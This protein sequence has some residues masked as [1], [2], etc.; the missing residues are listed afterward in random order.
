MAD[1]MKA[2]LTNILIYRIVLAISVILGS[3]K[4]FE[5]VQFVFE[6]F[7]PLKA[8]ETF[9]VPIRNVFDN[10]LDSS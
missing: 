6:N 7:Y 3:N 5:H 9:L 4:K 8:I 1:R 2:K 10:V